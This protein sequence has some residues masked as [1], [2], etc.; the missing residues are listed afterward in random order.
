MAITYRTTGTWGAGKGSPLT[1]VEVDLN[2]WDFQQQINA[3]IADP[4]EP[5]QIASF[6]L[7]GRLLSV[8]MANG[9]V[10]GP[11]ALPV[12]TFRD[13]GD[14]AA[15]TAYLAFDF[16]KVPLLGLYLALENFTS[17]LVFDANAVNVGGEPLLRKLIGQ[18]DETTQKI[19]FN[20]IGPFPSDRSVLF[21]YQTDDA[22]II[23]SDAPG[24]TMLGVAASA[25]DL[26]FPIEH[27][28]AVVGSLEFLAGVGGGA[29]GSQQG[30]VLFN[31]DVILDPLDFLTVH[32]PVSVTDT[33][34]ARLSLT[35]TAIKN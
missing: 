1:S 20:W 29:A 10:F 9:T 19:A 8:V 24:I 12:A 2:F 18:V 22:I 5:N 27:N 4:L 13:R 6:S 11:Y 28:G 14:W 35:I 26:S 31:Y 25:N 33:T 23:S 32:A 7:S 16:F 17:G 21:T 30:E 3:L 15:S 34:A